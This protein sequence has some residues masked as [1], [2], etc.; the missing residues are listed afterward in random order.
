M[1]G[2]KRDSQG[3]IIIQ[4]STTQQIAELFGIDLTNTS[5]LPS[6]GRFS[7]TALIY[8]GDISILTVSNE[9]SGFL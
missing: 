7:T 5:L 8:A 6:L 3:Y 9:L 4:D 2:K 1:D